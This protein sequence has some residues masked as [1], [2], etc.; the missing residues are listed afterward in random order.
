[1][2]GGEPSLNTMVTVSPITSGG[3]TGS[4]TLAG[5]LNTTEPGG[6]RPGISWGK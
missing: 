6:Y 1:M 4:G 2:G 3:A 5:Y